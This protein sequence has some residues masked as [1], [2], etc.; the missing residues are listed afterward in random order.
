MHSK[1]LSLP[2]VIDFDLCSL[3]MNRYANALGGGDVW[4]EQHLPGVGWDQP[5][6]HVSRVFIFRHAGA[7]AT[8]T[9]RVLAIPTYMCSILV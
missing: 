5:F 1:I 2:G 4:F 6:L 8:L 7:M 3:L 9:P